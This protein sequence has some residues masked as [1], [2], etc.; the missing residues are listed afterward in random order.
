MKQITFLLL[1]CLL[2]VPTCYGGYFANKEIS[3]G[4]YLTK[5]LYLNKPADE[6]GCTWEEI[7]RPTDVEIY[8]PPKTEEQ[9]REELI[10]N[11]ILSTQR[12]KAI[13]DLKTDGQLPSN[14]TDRIR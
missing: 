6:I 8:F 1:F 7:N 3:T 10:R 13:E 9:L 4:R 12:E 5:G 2:I 14:F 11:K